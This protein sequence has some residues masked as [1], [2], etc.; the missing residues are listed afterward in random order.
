MRWSLHAVW[1]CSVEPTER[2][3]HHTPKQVRQP[4]VHHPPPR[5]VPRKQGVD[6]P[7]SCTAASTPMCEPHACLSDTAAD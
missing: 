2:V 7:R 4:C 5:H 3:L 1:R 6:A